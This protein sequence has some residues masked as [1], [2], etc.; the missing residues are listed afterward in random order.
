VFTL[1]H[2]QSCAYIYIVLLEENQEKGF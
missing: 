2:A 1:K